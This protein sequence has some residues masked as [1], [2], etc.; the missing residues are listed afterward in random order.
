[1]NKRLVKSIAGLAAHVVCAGGL[2]TAAHYYTV[3][4]A[5]ETHVAA[6]GT[7]HDT[8]EP[9]NI[10]L[11]CSSAFA[12]PIRAAIS[13]FEAE[14]PQ[15]KID[16]ITS[17]SR[18]CL[19]DLLGGD[20]QVAIL[21]RDMSVNE[22]E[23]S[24]ELDR[25]LQIS[26]L[27]YDGI[28]VLVHP[29]VGRLLPE[30]DANV[31]RRLFITGDMQR[32]EAIT[33]GNVQGPITLVVSKSS[34]DVTTCFIQALD[35][36][37]SALATNVKQ[38]RDDQAVANEITSN[39]TAIGFVPT[40]VQANGL[41]T[42]AINSGKQATRPHEEAVRAHV[43]PLELKAVAIANTDRDEGTELFYRYLT[44]DAGQ[45]VLSNA[46]IVTTLEPP[47][48]PEPTPVDPEE[49]A[50]AH[51]GG[52]GGAAGGGSGGGHGEKPASSGAHH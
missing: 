37:E 9:I 21:A 45:Y 44:S 46:G 29:S 20:A 30:V 32:W 2:A 7:A 48:P 4:P 10:R 49:E 16:C 14:H 35:P 31:L 26:T 8:E 43:Y 5:A 40:Q 38:L 13:S 34:S 22:W 23:R 36:R 42:L 39:R 6:H 50:A 12:G 33:G 27:G 51:G 15:Y 47:P 3:L 11:S 25:S 18:F 52:H 19:R 24:V 1:M 41:T 17:D 28:K